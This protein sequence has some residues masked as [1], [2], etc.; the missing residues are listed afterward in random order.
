MAGVAVFEL[1]SPATTEVE[2]AK[3]RTNDADTVMEDKECI[4]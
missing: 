4:E 3:V 2:H 1:G